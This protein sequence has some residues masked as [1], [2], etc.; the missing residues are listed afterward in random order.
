[1]ASAN[2]VRVRFAPSPTGRLHVGNVRTALFNWLF[3]RQRGGRFILR[4]EDTDLERSRPE[5]ERHIYEDLKWLGLTWDEGPDV[6]GPYGPYRQSERL[7]LYREAADRL[8]QSGRAYRCF[9]T[10]E[11]LDAER[12]RA[13]AQGL[14]YVYS[15]RCRRL[16]SDEV[17][18]KL[19]QKKPFTVRFRVEP[20][21]ITWTDLVR[22]RV[23]W[24]AELLGDFVIMKSDG[25]PVYN[26]AVVIDD[27][28]MKITHVIRGDGHLPNT[29]RQIVLYRAL[30]GSP[31]QFGHLS[32]I[33]GPD[34]TKLSKRHG[35]TSI[36]EF[37]E[38]GYL[39]EALFNFLA[40]LGWSPA[41]GS[42]ILSREELI[43]QFSLDRVVKAPA[44]FDVG[45][46]NWM[47]RHY[48]R[49]M[50]RE[51]LIDLAARY[52]VKANR[53]EDGPLDD[54]TRRWLG[55][56]LD[57]VITHLDTLAQVV[58]E[59]EIVFEYDLD[60]A[61]QSEEVR[62]TLEDEGALQVIEALREELADV[63]EVTV[64]AFQRAT[65]AVKER[66]GRKGRALFHP[67]RIALTGRPSGPELVKLIPI[68]EM[69]SRLNL[70]API[71]SVSHRLD[72]FLQYAT[73]WRRRGR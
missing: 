68:Y 21:L 45:K 43:G 64:E 39:P 44:I 7:Q 23:E 37:R 47:N 58:E 54:A 25:W 66:T 59:T 41:G 24:Q 13:K 52:L 61:S 48:L 62:Q 5:Y 26:F 56:V 27:M 22:G 38:R 50:D 46:L 18:L 33:L 72:A 40:L 51:R 55:L 2:D 49:Q 32:T 35:A 60:R 4:I 15:G 70:P 20:G 65:R 1:M 42:E 3:A 57:A 28:A 6:G 69:G 63:S 10:P 30:G 29:P 34:G 19:N 17:A 8:L 67:I 71:P 73:H 31:P 14:P 11:E 53:L 16:T 12:Q 36:G 9:C